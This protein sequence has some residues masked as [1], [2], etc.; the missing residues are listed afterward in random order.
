MCI[1]KQNI[2]VS[3]QMIHIS[4]ILLNSCIITGL[5]ISLLL[6][7]VYSLRTPLSE[8]GRESERETVRRRDVDE[9]SVLCLCEIPL[10]PALCVQA[11]HWGSTLSTFSIFFPVLRL[12]KASDEVDCKLCSKGFCPLLHLWLQVSF[13]LVSRTFPEV[14]PCLLFC[15][16]VT[17]G[18]A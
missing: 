8:M 1:F 12:E 2:L 16:A 13:C 15:F 6:Q 10:M 9:M 4:V 11:R 7:T 5:M 17:W 18:P 3:I 14:T